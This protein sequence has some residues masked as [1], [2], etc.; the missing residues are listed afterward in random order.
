M[1]AARQVRAMVGMVAGEVL[2]GGVEGLLE[3][4]RRFIGGM[5]ETQ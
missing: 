2:S 1:A 4:C 5:D 3:V